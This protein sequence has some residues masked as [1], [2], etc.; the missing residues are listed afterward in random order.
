MVSVATGVTCGSFAQ[1]D[2]SRAD[3]SKAAATLIGLGVS[4][5][6]QSQSRYARKSPAQDV[7]AGQPERNAASVLVFL[8]QLLPRNLLLR[9]IGQFKNEVD[10]FVFE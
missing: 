8:E 7:D 1:S 4:P 3:L 6:R 9:D 5:F 10:D 2:L